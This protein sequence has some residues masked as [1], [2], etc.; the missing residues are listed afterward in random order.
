VSQ[1][2]PRTGREAAERLNLVALSLFYAEIWDVFYLTAD[3]RADST[4]PL[5]G[6]YLEATARSLFKAHGVVPVD[7]DY[8]CVGDIVKAIKGLPPSAIVKPFW[9]VEPPADNSPAVRLTH[10]VSLLSQ[11]GLAPELRLGVELIPASGQEGENED[12]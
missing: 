4:A 12:V 9:G 7:G 3:D 6:E 1:S 10:V 8:V 2:T 5:D 11:C